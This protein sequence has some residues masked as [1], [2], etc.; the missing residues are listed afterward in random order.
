MAQIIELFDR[1][2]DFSNE[3]QAPV[4]SSPDAAASHL[5]ALFIAANQIVRRSGSV[6]E[7][8]IRG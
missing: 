3:E 2:V 8:Q 5:P 4:L 6:N 7:T 1:A